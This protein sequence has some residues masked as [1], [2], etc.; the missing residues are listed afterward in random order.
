VVNETALKRI[1][2]VIEDAKSAGAGK[3]LMG[4]DRLAGEL[5]DGY[6]IANTV[7]VDV[8]PASDLAM[9]EVF[10]PVLAVTPFDTEEEA[11]QIANM[12]TYGLSHYLQTRDPRRIRRMVPRLN[13]GTVGVNTGAS[14]SPTAPY[15][16]V[17]ASGFGREGGRLGVEEFTRI[18]TVLEN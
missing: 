14:F 15:G 6:F 10:G 2:G 12:T 4:G 18:K 5:A 8:D 17:G 11:V 16:G 1:L 3:L 9:K 13:A 7:F